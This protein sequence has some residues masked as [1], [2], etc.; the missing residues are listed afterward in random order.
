MWQS[1]IA[2]R[3]EECVRTL[4]N[5]WMAFKSAASLRSALV[6]VNDSIPMEKKAGVVYKVPDSCGK[7][8]IGETKRTLE[9]R[10]TET[11]CCSPLRTAREVSNRRTCLAGWAYDRLE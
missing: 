3:S 11:S 5:I 7:V 6:K 4:Y 10:L 1:Y 8:Y 2:N 9:I